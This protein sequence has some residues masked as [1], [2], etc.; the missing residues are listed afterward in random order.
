MIPARQCRTGEVVS[1]RMARLSC[2]HTYT[3][4]LQRWAAFF[5]CTGVW[6]AVGRY[7]WSRWN[8]VGKDL[9]HDSRVHFGGSAFSPCLCDPRC[10]LT[11]QAGRLKLWQNPHTC[12]G[13]GPN[14]ATCCSNT[15]R[16]AASKIP[17]IHSMSF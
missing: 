17:R 15:Q 13:N 16:K 4:R 2:F 5:S 1:V 7:I 9:N 14:F 8:K 10:S 6:P 11:G 12:T 3:K